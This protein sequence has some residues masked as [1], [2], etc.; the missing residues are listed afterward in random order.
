MKTERLPR[1]LAAAAALIAL[2]LA[3][4]ALGMAMTGPAGAA[5]PSPQETRPASG[6]AQVR[7]GSADGIVRFRE[8]VD[9]GPAER[10]ANVVSFG[11][12]VTVAGTVDEAVVV[13]GADV[14][15]LPTAVVGA[16]M[17]A[18]DASLVL[19]GGTLTR[20]PGAQVVGDVQRFDG[21]RWGEAA[22]WATRHTFIDPWWGFTFMGWVVQTAFFLVLALV[23][24]A[25][26]PR[27][28]LAVQRHL[29]LKPAPSLGWGALTFFI[30][31][32]ALLVVLVI[33]IVGLL[34]VLPYV[35]VL[36]L[37]YFFV[38]TSVAAFVARR[39]LGGSAQHDNLMLATTLGVLGTTVVSRIP[40]VGSL[41]ILVMIVFGTGAAALA[42][43]EWRRGRRLAPAPAGA[44]AAV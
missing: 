10:V 36:L 35:L 5:S 31:A 21:A 26:M 12:D 34:L 9:I 29:A 16:N 1:V 14:H 7:V 38:T 23:A 40:V 24:A 32:P 6:Q 37:A 18:G 25:L 43:V 20:D 22:N 41:V 2:A 42:I 11:G 13:F 15:L 19:F 8:P 30:V 3:L 4:V 44:P 33:S 39:A 17:N 28:L 27:Q